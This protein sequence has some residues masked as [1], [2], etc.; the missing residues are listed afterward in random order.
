M[1]PA[2]RSVEPPAPFSIARD[3]APGRYPLDRV[4]PGLVEVEAFR[5]LGKE[6][7]ERKAL[8]RT[9]IEV[10]SDDIWMYVA[11]HVIPKTRRPGWEPVV[12]PQDCVV[13]GHGHLAE[14]PALIVYLDILHELCHVLQRK[15]G[16]ELWDRKFAYVD[17]PT[18]LEAYEVAVR[19]ARR[20]GADDAFLRDYLRVEWVT[21]RDFRR[22][23][24]HL[25]VT[26]S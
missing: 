25:G 22:L 18:E 16:R 13:V 2:R 15:A 17:R 12:S 10:I 3:L 9:Q 7:G 14:S 1:A 20:L 8:E 6:N 4:F 11:P 19:E 23:L 5:G 21:D 26:A 24:K